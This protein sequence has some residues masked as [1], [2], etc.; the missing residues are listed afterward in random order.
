[1]RSERFSHLAAVISLRTFF[2]TSSFSS[3]FYHKDELEKSGNLPNH[4]SPL[5][6]L[7]N[8][9]VCHFSLVFSFRIVLCYV[10]PPQTHP[11]TPT[12]TLLTLQAESPASHNGE[13]HW[14][15]CW[16]KWHWYRFCSERFSF[17][18]TII[19]PM[20]IL[21]FRD[22]V[23]RREN[24]RSLRAFHKKWCYCA[25]REGSGKKIT[26]VVYS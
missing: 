23:T 8:K 25:N 19:P 10:L 22:A 9:S 13:S 7:L 17:L 16:T 3:Y 14:N 12:P 21:I 24:R 2:A 4:L 6:Y 5:F 1:M 15:F 26:S 11:P 20:L 18:V